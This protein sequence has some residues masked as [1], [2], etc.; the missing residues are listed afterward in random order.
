MKGNFDMVQRQS[1][2]YNNIHFGVFTFNGGRE[3]SR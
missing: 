2:G 3:G 1:C